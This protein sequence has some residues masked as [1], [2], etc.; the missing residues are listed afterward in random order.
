[1]TTGANMNELDTIKQIVESLQGLEITR[2]IDLAI[3]NTK[4]VE[5]IIE[6]KKLR[7]DLDN[8]I[9][10]LCDRYRSDINTYYENQQVVA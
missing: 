1:M 6:Y 3:D 10:D 5:R 4:V 7:E 9:F 8:L 2:E